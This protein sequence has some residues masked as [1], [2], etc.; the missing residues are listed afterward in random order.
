MPTANSKYILSDLSAR[1]E[2][3]LHGDGSHQIEG[4]GTLKSA[5]SAMVTFLANSSYRKDLPAT[6]AGAVILRETD[7]QACPVNC[8]VAADPYLAY[9]RMA[10]LFDPSPAAV[11]GIHPSAVVDPR[12]ELVPA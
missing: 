6:R 1:F 3:E 11:P 4:V 2:L 5:S 10:A 12:P 8:L 9:A 7:A